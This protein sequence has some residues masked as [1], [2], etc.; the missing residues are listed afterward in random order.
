MRKLTLAA[1]AALAS[2]CSSGTAS[3]NTSVTPATG[4]TSTASTAPDPCAGSACSV[5][6][7]VDPGV[8]PEYTR[9]QVNYK[10]FQG[11]PRTLGVTGASGFRGLPAVATSV[12]PVFTVPSSFKGRYGT[13]V[14]FE[15]PNPQSGWVIVDFAA[16]TTAAVDFGQVWTGNALQTDQVV[17][18]KNASFERNACR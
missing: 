17:A 6:V 11:C 1:L 12:N 8:A 16:G 2:A 10:L 13:V 14:R 9:R 18:N 3:T 7:S 4:A 15:G 5:R